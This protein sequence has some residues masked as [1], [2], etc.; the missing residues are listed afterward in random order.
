MYA[1]VC[2]CVYVLA[3]CNSLHLFLLHFGIIHHANIFM[4]IKRKERPTLPSCLVDNE[5]IEGVVLHAQ[6]NR[7]EA[8]SGTTPVHSLPGVLQKQKLTHTKTNCL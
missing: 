8:E 7:T 2:V 3:N 5:V 6:G 4:N 1:C